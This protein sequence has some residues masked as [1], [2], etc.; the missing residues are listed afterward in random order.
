MDDSTPLDSMPGVETRITDLS[1]LDDHIPFAFAAGTVYNP[2]TLSQ[3][4]MP[5]AQDRD[6]FIRCQPGEINGLHEAKGFN[7]MNL[8]DTPPNGKGNSTGN[9]SMPNGHT[10]RSD[11][12]TVPH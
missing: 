7:C 6:A 1:F 10:A 5:K 12:L 3:R 9:S 4:D 2:S 11:D 8:D